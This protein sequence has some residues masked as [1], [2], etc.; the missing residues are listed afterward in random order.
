MLKNMFCS[1]KGEPILTITYWCCITL[2]GE[3]SVSMENKFSIKKR[4]NLS[5]KKLDFSTKK[6]DKT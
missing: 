5:L 3:F 2:H 1:I 6:E 4:N